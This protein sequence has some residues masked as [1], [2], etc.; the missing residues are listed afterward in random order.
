MKNWLKLYFRLV[1]LFAALANSGSK[2][3]IEGGHTKIGVQLSPHLVV[4]HCWRRP[5]PVGDPVHRR[6]RATIVAVV[7]CPLAAPKY[8]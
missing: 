6:V 8:R 3:D 2:M 5:A 1:T 7:W 4:Q